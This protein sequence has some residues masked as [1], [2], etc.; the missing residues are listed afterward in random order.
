MSLAPSG[1]VVRVRR[2]EDVLNTWSLTV[3]HNGYTPSQI[4]GSGSGEAVDPERGE[5]EMER[6]RSLTKEWRRG[7]FCA[8][9]DQTGR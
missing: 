4:M 5:N 8:F 9:R 2:H 3:V 7:G 6:G 1:F